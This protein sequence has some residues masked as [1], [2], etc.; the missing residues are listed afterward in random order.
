MFQRRLMTTPTWTT[1]HKNALTLLST[2]RQ[3]AWAVE[4][5]ASLE[6]AGGFSPSSRLTSLTRDMVK[7]RRADLVEAVF[8]FWA[9]TCDET[10]LRFL[11]DTLSTH[12]KRTGTD[13]TPILDS[14][15]NDV[16]DILAK[17]RF[18]DLIAQDAGTNL[19]QAF[20]NSLNA[21]GKQALFGILCLGSGFLTAC[22]NQ[23]TRFLSSVIALSFAKADVFQPMNLIRFDP[24]T[25]DRHLDI[26]E[27][28][29]TSNT[30][31][32]QNAAA[33]SRLAVALARHLYANN[34][35]TVSD[36]FKS[37]RPGSLWIA[38]LMDAIP[39]TSWFPENTPLVA[40][41]G[42]MLMIRPESAHER[43]RL[44]HT[45]NL[46]ED[47][48]EGFVRDRLLTNGIPTS[49]LAQPSPPG[50]FP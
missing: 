22:Q 15:E 45:R 29:L 31:C 46:F 25:R 12:G 35:L 10:F 50:F 21:L 7:K 44:Q 17:H 47:D 33:K 36:M 37:K 6:D 32:P 9:D 11:L 18:P 19:C 30:P 34:T 39:N 14:P 27:S 23:K 28:A 1:L 49:P 8:V 13:F 3:G 40:P 16:A 41:N 42:D 4:A 38:H 5:K 48:P 2:W 26:L 43:A 24:K 20:H